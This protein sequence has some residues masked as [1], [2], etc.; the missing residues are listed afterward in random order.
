MARPPDPHLL[1]PTA[2]AA[3]VPTAP[4]MTQ[5][6]AAPQG[7]FVPAPL[8]VV[9]TM[10]PHG[11]R[12][13]LLPGP[14]DTIFD[15]APGAGAPQ[16]VQI[17]VAHA[18]EEAR[19]ALQWVA[20]RYAGI[21]YVDSAASPRAGSAERITLVARIGDRVAGTLSLG[22]DRGGDLAADEEYRA[23]IDALRARGAVLGEITGLAVDRQAS[24]RS[25]LAALFN[26]GYLYLRRIWRCTDLLVEVTPAHA[27]FYEHSLQFRRIGAPRVCA[28]VGVEGVLLRLDLAQTQQAVARLAGTADPHQPN[29]SLYAYFLPPKREAR[30]VARLL[31]TP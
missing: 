10:G 18:G 19:P 12:D 3:R 8:R 25:L 30:V 22:R 23:E 15:A 4:A 26:I 29:R 14:V 2:P 11:W 27:R 7:G 17:S 16:A 1:P 28:R 9:A 5:P 24:S 21:G 6:G 31:L 20:Q 13:P